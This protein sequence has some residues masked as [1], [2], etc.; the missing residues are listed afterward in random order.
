M[1]PQQVETLFRMGKDYAF[2]RWSCPIAP[3]V[4]G[5]DDAT[6]AVVKGAF[7]AVVALAGHRMAGNDPELGANCMVFFLRDWGELAGLPQ[8]ERLL[9][10]VSDLAA[11][12]QADDADRYRGLH[13]DDSGAIRSAFVF[14][15]MSGPLAD[16]PAEDLALAEVVQVILRWSDSAFATASPLARHDGRTILRPEIAALIRAAYDPVL[17]AASRDPAHALR[18]A[19]RLR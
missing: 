14:L 15:R 17:P 7:E 2:A 6:L 1:T 13:F 18:L 4:F 16:I 8:L 5:V 9:P 3:V 19:A 12:L 11:R 10:G